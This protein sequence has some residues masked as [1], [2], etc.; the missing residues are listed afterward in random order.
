VFIFFLMSLL[1][2]PPGY[3]KPVSGHWPTSAA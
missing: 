3:G 1:T 2:F